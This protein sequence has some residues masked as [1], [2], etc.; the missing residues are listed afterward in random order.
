[1]RA[2]IQTIPMGGGGGGG[3]SNCFSREVRSIFSRKQMAT[4][5]FHGEVPTPCPLCLSPYQSFKQFE[6]TFYFLFFCWAWSI[7]KTSANYISCR[8]GQRQWG[9]LTPLFAYRIRI[10]QY[11]NKTEK[12]HPEK[13][14][15]LLVEIASADPEGGQG[16]R[17]PTPWK[18]TSYMGFYRV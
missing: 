8:Q 18:I 11:L 6:F 5:D 10:Y 13:S 2:R 1:M 9:R 4:Y 16:V 3:G 17:T 15:L 14:Y 7:H 12:Y